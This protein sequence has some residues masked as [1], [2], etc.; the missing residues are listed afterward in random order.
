MPSFSYKE[1]K[2]ALFIS[3]KRPLIQLDIYSAKSGRWVQFENVLADT[4]AD[5]CLLPRFMGNVLVD[6]VT[7]GEYK[8]IRG[9]VPNTFLNG[10]IHNLKIRIDDKELIAPVF[11]ADS[12]DV[13][14]IF[15]RVNAMDLFNA[16]FD[17]DMVKIELK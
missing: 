7:R 14:P 11:I 13:T 15:G 4:G 6:D 17:G 5:I 8:K 12:E 2:S 1:G 3:I 9:V 10:F 16:C